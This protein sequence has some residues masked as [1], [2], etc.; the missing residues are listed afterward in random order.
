MLVNIRANIVC[1][2]EFSVNL[3][4][5]F[6]VNIKCDCNIKHPKLCL[7]CTNVD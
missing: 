4:L 7:V 6:G 5:V 1:K 2:N 3:M